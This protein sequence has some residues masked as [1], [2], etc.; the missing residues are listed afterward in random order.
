M[1]AQV[2]PPGTLLAVQVGPFQHI[3]FATDHFASGEQC[4]ISSSRRKGCVTEEPLSR[5]AGGRKIA[6]LGS[7]LYSAVGDVLRRARSML[8]TPWTIF[9]NCEHFVA[10]AL[11]LRPT[12]RQLQAT[13]MIA[14]GVLLLGYLLGKK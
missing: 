5:F 1:Y 12:S 14:L 4:V 3:G 10:K 13:G 8:G 6:V 11:G 2:F 7:V 9:N